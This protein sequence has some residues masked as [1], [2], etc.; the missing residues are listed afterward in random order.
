MRGPAVELSIG[1]AGSESHQDSIYSLLLSAGIILRQAFPLVGVRWLLE[2]QAT[3]CP[4]EWEDFLKVLTKALQLKLTFSDWLPWVTCPPCHP[5]KCN[6]LIGQTS[7][8]CSPLEHW[9]G[10]A[11]PKLLGWWCWKVVSQKK[12]MGNGS[13][14]NVKLQIPLQNSVLP[15]PKGQKSQPNLIQSKP[16][17]T[18][19]Q[20]FQVKKKS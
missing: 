11:P 16:N 12:G 19:Y 8:T 7:V 6:A 9:E 18:G 14:T 17:F 1:T 20:S 2:P 4:V 3:N 15:D 10:S 13:C 5:G